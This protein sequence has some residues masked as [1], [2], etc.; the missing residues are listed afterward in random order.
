MIKKIAIAL[1]ALI[2]VSLI[3]KFFTVGI[4]SKARTNTLIKYIPE[5]AALIIES[6]NIQKITGEL[7]DREN[8]L[9]NY[10]SQ[11]YPFFLLQQEFEF[12]DSALNSNK[13]ITPYLSNNLCEISFHFMGKRE[14]EVLYQIA[15]PEDANDE[16]IDTL[17]SQIFSKHTIITKK[18]YE[19]T[20]ISIYTLKN[21]KAAFFLY[22]N[23]ESILFSSS[24]ILIE[25]TI[26]KKDKA[27][28]FL[29]QPTFTE[30]YNK[31]NKNA[32]ANVFINLQNFSSVL[33]AYTSN[34]VTTNTLQQFPNWFGFD[35][36]LENE[37]VYLNGITNA[38]T[39][40]WNYL[41]AFKGQSA[42]ESELINIFPENTAAFITVNFSD[43][44]LFNQNYKKYLEQ[45]SQINAY[46]AKISALKA[47]TSLD[48]ELFFNTY[49]GNELALIY[50]TDNQIE[51][52]IVV[53]K[54]NNKNN[55]KEE[56]VT[57][58]K[59]L[60]K[61]D[62]TAL[63]ETTSTLIISAKETYEMYH[64]S[65]ANPLSVLYGSIFKSPNAKFYTVFDEYLLIGST[66]EKLEN[67]INLNS[68]NKLFKNTV[69]YNELT[70]I[71]KKKNTIL[72]YS[73]PI[74]S[75]KLYYFMLNKKYA[76]ELK[77]NQKK[78]NKY[79]PFTIQI[80]PSD[81]EDFY[82]I[83]LSLLFDKDKKPKIEKHWELK[84]DTLALRRPQLFK[85][86]YNGETEIFTQ[87][88]NN[89]IYLIDK[90]GTILFKR[91]IKYKIQ[92][93]AKQ[94]DYYTNTKL[95]IL[96]AAGDELYLIDREGKDVEK[97]PIKLS[98]KAT[99]GVAV[100]DY[101]NDRKYRF[102]V[103]CVNKQVYAYSK[104][105]ELLS[106]W[107]FKATSPIIKLPKHVRIENNDYILIATRE[108]LQILNRKGEERIKLKTNIAI[109]EN[110]SLNFVS[111]EKPY[112]LSSNTEGEIVKIY[113]DG[114]VKT[115]K[116][117]E[118]DEESLFTLADIDNNR[119]SDYVVVSGKIVEIYDHNYNAT[120]KYES[121][122]SLV[123]QPYV[124]GFANDKKM[125][126]LFAK[127]DNLIYLF[128][129]K[130]RLN[131]FFPLPSI[132]PFVIGFAEQTETGMTYSLICSG[133]NSTL[134]S[135]KIDD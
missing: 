21:R 38:T 90:S 97:F 118:M 109:A 22:K 78:I 26:R 88:E 54:L 53:A 85:N 27:N 101:E 71:S 62:S 103:A 5:S 33:E 37:A 32:L 70:E 81:I 126:G 48:F 57:T 69:A 77:L 3:V 129:S 74:L 51:E 36:L 18:I 128:D 14:P 132:S 50:T 121:S 115:H 106:S 96:F 82:N 117:S 11:I 114:T 79:L 10:M 4:T 42:Q 107:N 99:N 75:K 133:E 41:R 120:E 56:L 1:A 63:E 64:F 47:K 35:L 23:E 19:N 9:W 34:N 89:N 130:L 95:Q 6:D 76:Q 29:N 60:S 12:L 104:E 25:E 105:G 116:L 108:K 13:K 52:P 44:K 45:T 46:N 123:G 24:E 98:S 31:L 17:L 94:I 134:I 135:Y 113:F 67:F 111:T 92:G 20:Q 125:I 87:D 61:V 110:S 80:T 124:F 28:N 40:K 16:D 72:V 58:L 131:D 7:S 102:F 91:H 127:E 15:K 43:I 83:N 68:K 84:L 65:I 93:E 73:D 39:G 100:F 86:H 8:E 112:I 49:L 55:A 119:K 2:I 66:V 122:E 30:V 59:A